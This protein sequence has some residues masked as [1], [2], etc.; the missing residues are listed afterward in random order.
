MRQVSVASVHVDLPDT[1]ATVVLQEIEPPYREVVIPIGL[2][3]G[4]AIAHAWRGIES[5]RP[6]THDLFTSVLKELA[7]SLEVVE[8]TAVEHRTYLAQITLVSGSSTRV[9]PCRPSDGLALALRQALPV[10]IMVDED[11]LS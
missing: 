7:V 9:L 2:P 4:A 10:P 6:L 8:V 1:H 3:E 5:P 11:L